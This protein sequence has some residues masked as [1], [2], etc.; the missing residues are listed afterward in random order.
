MKPQFGVSVRKHN[1]SDQARN[2]TA[3][4]QR[5]RGKEKNNFELKPVIKSFLGVLR[6]FAVQ[7]FIAQVC[8]EGN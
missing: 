2:F 4:A 1:D 5:S 3:R 7:R 8:L 6:A